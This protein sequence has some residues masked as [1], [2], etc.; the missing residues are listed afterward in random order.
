MNARPRLLQGRIGY[1][2]ES[3]NCK[4]AYHQLILVSYED[5]LMQCF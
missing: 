4:S 2:T 3:H 5:E 1:E